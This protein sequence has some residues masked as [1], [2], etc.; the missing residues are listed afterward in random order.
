MDKKLTTKEW[1]EERKR[2]KAQMV[3]MQRLPYEV[4]VKRAELRAIEFVEKLDDLGMSAHVSV[5]GLDSIT[6][7]L[8]LRKI[9]IDVPAISVTSLE[10]RSIQKVHKDLGIIPVKPGKTKVQIINEV[11][12]PVISKKIAGRIDTLQHPTNKNETVRHAIIT[13]ECGEQGHFAKNSRMKLPQKWLEL[14]AGYENENEGVNYQ[15]APFKVSNKCCKFLKEDPCD[16]WAKENHSAP[17]L[18]L[19]ASEGGQREEAL[20]EH[21]CNYFGK[22]VIR[23]APFAPFMRQDLLQLALDLNVPV[24]EIYGEI[25][26]KADGTLYTTEAQRT[27]C[28]MCGFGIHMEKRPHRF[29]KLRERNEKEWEFWMYKCY[30]DPETGEK[31]GWGRVLDYIGVE[32]EDRYFDMD[33]HQID[34]FDFIKV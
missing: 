12:F 26:R 14:F 11:G 22:S 6:L 31:F 24:P 9:G 19:M 7:L 18:G 33:K 27:G 29:D 23:S 10:D 34:I 32:W 16:Q 13:G 8:F 5:G 4:K 1:K 17:F 21:G 2:K 20:V 30:T 3:A 28:S 25:A 15:I